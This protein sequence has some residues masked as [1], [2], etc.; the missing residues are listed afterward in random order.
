MTQ[1]QDSPFHDGSTR[2]ES[3]PGQRIPKAL[4]L[5]AQIRKAWGEY[6]RRQADA[7]PRDDLFKLR[8]KR[9]A[10]MYRFLE[11]EDRP[12]TNAADLREDDALVLLQ[13]WRRER[14][15]PATIRSQWSMLRVWAEAIGQPGMIK[16]L[17]VYWKEAPKSTKPKGAAAHPGRHKDQRLLAALLKSRDRTHYWIERTC[18][19]LRIS[20]Q[21]ALDLVP[22]DALE[23]PDASVL[24]KAA[25]A[26]ARD[27]E[28][29]SGLLAGLTEFLSECGRPSLIWSELSAGHA[30]RKHENHLAY[31]RRKL[32]LDED[33]SDLVR[34]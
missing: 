30:L 28:A 6:M 2:A 16:S 13:R 9:V 29:C 4:S 10:R 7:P 11:A 26:M 23:G 8:C 22:A 17:S 12:L 3:P 32:R 24:A 5:E 25:R 33:I 19:V 18:Q 31:M 34:P 21:Q 14:L 27:P 20:V 1:L 15:S